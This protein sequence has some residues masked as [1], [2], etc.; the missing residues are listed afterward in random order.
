LHDL[1]GASFVFNRAITTL[2][3]DRDFACFGLADG[4][5]AMLRAHWEGAP[6]LGPRPGGGVHILAGTAPP[7]P[8]A[9]F[10]MHKGAVLALA[11]DPLGGIVSGGTDGELRRLIDGEIQNLE[12]RPRRQI[13]AVAAGRGGRRAFAAGRQA[14]SLGPDAR[15]VTTPGPVTAL[16]Y[17]PAG[18]HLAVGFDGGVSLEA[19]GIRLA[20]QLERAGS[21]NL[22]AW[23]KDG[24]MVAAGSAESGVAVRDRYAPAWMPQ[25]DGLRGPPTALAFTADG[26][27]VIAGADFAQYWRAGDVVADLGGGLRAPI[28][29]HPRLNLIAGADVQGRILLRRIGLPD[30]M[31]LREPGAAPTYLAFAPDGQALAFAAEDGEAGTVLLPDLLFRTGETPC[32]T[33]LNPRTVSLR[34]L[35]PSRTR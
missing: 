19:C 31:I 6:T 14:D 2:V 26:A 8:P 9:I 33:R 24:G 11:A 5:V 28:A 29:C 4:A 20:S 32:M 30:A 23:S 22:L 21:H 18:L 17:D 12:S 7:P 34:R 10:P 35:A 16:A 15:R 3:W 1:L 13:A 27:L 25:I